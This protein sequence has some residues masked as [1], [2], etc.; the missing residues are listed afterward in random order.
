MEELPRELSFGTIIGQY[1][2]LHPRTLQL[3][4][5]TC[6][7]WQSQLDNNNKLWS[8]SLEQIS[9][10]QVKTYL[11]SLKVP[12]FTWQA[13]LDETIVMKR[14]DDEAVFLGTKQALTESKRLCFNCGKL[15]S[16]ATIFEPQDRCITHPVPLYWRHDTVS[17]DGGGFSWDYKGF[18]CCGENPDTSTE[19]GCLDTVHMDRLDTLAE[20]FN[21]DA[22]D[23]IEYLISFD[24]RNETYI[25]SVNVSD[26]EKRERE[27]DKD[28]NA[29]SRW[30]WIADAP[31]AVC[32]DCHHEKCLCGDDA[33][34]FDFEERDLR[35]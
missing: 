32:G 5:L 33:F 25:R 35:V 16:L 21:W 6:K 15:Y 18:P 12:Y 19:E 13:E 1:L 20:D 7:H 34:I 30:S 3:L 23:R 8:D 10:A 22:T 11:A 2:I 27:R 26:E 17:W 31:G 4:G 9:L 24:P 29:M 14:R 28:D